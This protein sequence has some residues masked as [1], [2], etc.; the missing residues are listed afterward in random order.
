MRRT[1]RLSGKRALGGPGFT[2]S[3]LAARCDLSR[4]PEQAYSGRFSRMPDVRRPSRPTSVVRGTY[5]TLGGRKISEVEKSPRQRMVSPSAVS[6]KHC[7]MS[8]HQQ[9][10]MLVSLLQVP[11]CK[12]L[13]LEQDLLHGSVTAKHVAA[14]LRFR[15]A[16]HINSPESRLSFTSYTCLTPM[17]VSASF[18]DLG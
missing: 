15:S 12:S 5:C 1:H 4:Q 2:P 11:H 17:L 13:G 6:T 8:T 7:P 10:Y 14:R 3:A 16:S 18:P 9:V